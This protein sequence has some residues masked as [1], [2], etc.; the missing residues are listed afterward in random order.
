MQPGDYQ[1]S[2][3]GLVLNEDGSVPPVLHQYD[4]LP[5]LKKRLQAGLL[6]AT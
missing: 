4:R 3:D 5:D 1:T 6:P 2:S